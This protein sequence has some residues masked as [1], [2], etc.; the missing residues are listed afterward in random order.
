[1]Q[2]ACQ[3]HFMPM[4]CR[5]IARWAVLQDGSD[6]TPQTAAIAPIVAWQQTGFS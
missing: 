1:M 3:P 4:R 5:G 6:A 2:V